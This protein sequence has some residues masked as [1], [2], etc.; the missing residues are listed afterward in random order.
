M[1]NGTTFHP[2][3]R[4]LFY[5]DFSGTHL[6]SVPADDAGILPLNG[7]VTVLRYTKWEFG[8]T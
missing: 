4:I 1:P 6:L 2:S 3:T 7:F 8:L 5:A